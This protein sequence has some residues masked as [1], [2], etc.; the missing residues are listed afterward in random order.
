MFNHALHEILPSSSWLFCS[1][2]A[3]SLA[4]SFV[5]PTSFSELI[6]QTLCWQPHP[7]VGLIQA[8]LLDKLSIIED[9]PPPVY[10]F[11]PG[12]SPHLKSFMSNFLFTSSLRCLVGISNLTHIILTPDLYP[13]NISSDSVLHFNKWWLHPLS[14]LKQKPWNH[15]ILKAFFFFPHSQIYHEAMWAVYKTKIHVVWS[16]LIPSFNWITSPDQ[17]HALNFALSSQS[18]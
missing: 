10:I 5:D 17:L 1:F 7:P 3:S 8:R 6:S 16:I 18:F 11:S 14:Y 2:F 12:L 13:P 4:A 9:P 15:P